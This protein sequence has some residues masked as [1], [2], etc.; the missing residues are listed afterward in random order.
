MRRM[1]KTIDADTAAILNGTSTRY[2][3]DER[4]TILFEKA[5]IYVN[6]QSTWHHQGYLAE[7]SQS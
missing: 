3:G 6:E 5:L 2:I 1:A 7:A 4:T